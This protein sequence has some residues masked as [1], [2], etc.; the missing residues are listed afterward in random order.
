M[1]TAARAARSSSRD[2]DGDGAG[3]AVSRGTGD[4]TR[5]CSST[6]DDAARGDCGIWLLSWRTW[7]ST[8]CSAG[9]AP[10]PRGK[11]SSC[12][13]ERSGAERYCVPCEAVTVRAGPGQG[14]LSLQCVVR[15]GN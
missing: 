6:A 3:S 9:P 4:Y 13:M 12:R 11:G 15:L 1:D 2:C 5:R 14:C 10:G 8:G 7:A